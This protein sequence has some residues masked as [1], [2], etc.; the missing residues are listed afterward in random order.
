M[1]DLGWM[2]RGFAGSRTYGLKT[3]TIL[4]RWCDDEGQTHRF[5]IPDSCHVP[6]GGVQLLSPQHWAKTQKDTHPLQETGS[7]VNAQEASLY[8]QQRKHKLVVPLS[9][10]DNVATFHLAL[11]YSK[12]EAFCTEVGP[13]DGETGKDPVVLD[14]GII[15]SE[16]E[17]ADEVQ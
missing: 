1:R 13:E 9:P 3:G 6:Q 2:T 8:L 11:G 16:D 17:D 10:E 5:V 12:F 14:T 15:I 7:D 4:W